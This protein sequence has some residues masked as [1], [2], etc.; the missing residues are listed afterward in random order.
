MSQDG[1]DG[2]KTEENGDLDLP[3]YDLDA[4]DNFDGLTEDPDP[5]TGLKENDALIEDTDLIIDEL[6]IDE[7]VDDDITDILK[8][9]RDFW[10]KKKDS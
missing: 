8:E 9:S 3:D 2:L 6:A 7:L 10:E 4:L 1:I 5:E